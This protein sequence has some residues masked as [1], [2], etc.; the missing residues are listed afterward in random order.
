MAATA[1]PVPCGTLQQDFTHIY[2][3]SVCVCACSICVCLH[4]YVYVYTHTSAHA[5]HSVF[6]ARRFESPTHTIPELLPFRVSSHHVTSPHPLP[7][8]HIPVTRKLSV[9]QQNMHFLTLCL[10][11][12][13]LLLKFCLR[14]SSNTTPLNSSGIPV[15]FSFKPLVLHGVHFAF[16]PHMPR[17]PPSR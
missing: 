8:T 17:A 13:M 4:T 1:N 5:W 10:P 16:D 15:T 9:L 3:P 14:L 12:I 6:K 11:P 7:R 2:Q